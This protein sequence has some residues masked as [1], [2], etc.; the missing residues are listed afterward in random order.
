LKSYAGKDLS[1]RQV[2]I[3]GSAANAKALGDS[4][5]AF[6]SF[7]SILQLVIKW[8]RTVE[9]A[10]YTTRLIKSIPVTILSAY[11]L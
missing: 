9:T 5:G 6:V 2:A 4:P 3:V 10:K 8:W 7:A 11:L 1:W